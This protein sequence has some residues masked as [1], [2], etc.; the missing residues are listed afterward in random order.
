[1]NGGNDRTEAGV[2]RALAWLAK[3][4]KLTDGYWEFDG[5]QKDNRI[6]AT[7]MCLLPFLAAGETHNSG[8]KYRQTVRRG[9]DYLKAH[10]DQSGE[11]S[12]NM[13]AQALAT[14][15]FCEAARLDARN[16]RRSTTTSIFEFL[17]QFSGVPRESELKVLARR[18]VEYIVKAQADNGSWGYTAGLEGDVSIVGWQIQALAMAR[19]AKISVPQAVFDKAAEFLDDSS[20][21]GG[22]TYGYRSKQASP[23]MTAVGL[24]CRQYMGAT[25][26][27]TFMA[28]GVAWMWDKFPPTEDDWNIDYLHHATRVVRNFDGPIWHRDWSP[29]VRYILEMKQIT[30]ATKGA[31]QADV[32]SFPRDNGIM[33]KCTGKLGTT[34][35]ACLTLEVFCC[36]PLR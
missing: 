33:G 3:Q 14:M 1:M 15:V 26:R 32:G 21:D 25:H 35:L 34:A 4:Q 29:M 11:I 10:L 17:N 16:N 5:A 6:A 18:A 8:K 9:L 13:Y 31:K 30:E 19:S 22:V 2:A 23:S 28:R 36:L 20:A 12:K 27:N 24:L 7:A